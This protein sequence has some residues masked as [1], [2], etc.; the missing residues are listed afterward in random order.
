MKEDHEKQFAEEHF[1]L[2]EDSLS[3][4]LGEINSYWESI[5]QINVD[6][7]LFP[8]Q[9]VDIDATADSEKILADINEQILN[10]HEL[11]EIF[12]KELKREYFELV[13]LALPNVITRL[14]VLVDQLEIRIVE[15]KM[16]NEPDKE[17]LRIRLS[18]LRENFRGTAK[19]TGLND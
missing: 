2:S 11:S 19:S 14:Q 1:T 17:S 10:L 3:A 18:E 16:A 6:E 7:H 4:F 5:E 12:R 15:L 8:E 9:K 13:C